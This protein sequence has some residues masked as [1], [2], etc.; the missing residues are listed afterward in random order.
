MDN[1]AFFYGGC[2]YTEVDEHDLNPVNIDLV[3]C[4]FKR[5]EY[6]VRNIDL[7]VNN[8]IKADGYNGS[9][10]FNVKVVDNGQTLPVEKIEIPGCVQ[11]FPNLDVGGSGG[12]AAV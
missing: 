12:F 11:V 8:F 3:M 6:V 5:E 4:T 1:Q 2:Y 7:I 9:K 10:H